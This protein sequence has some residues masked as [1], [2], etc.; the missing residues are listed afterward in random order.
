LRLALVLALALLAL[1]APARAA[2]L[3]VG[4][5][6][7][8]LVLGGDASAVAQWPALGVDVVRIHAQW[9][10]IAPAVRPAGFVAS[11]PASRGYDWSTLDRAVALIRA[12]G[13]RVALT[14]TGPGPLWTSSEPRKRNP[15]W[16]PSP[17]AF[18]AFAHAVAA[19]YGAVVDRYLVWNE[20][21]QG[22]WLQPQ[23]SCVRKV[24]TPVAPHEYRALVRAAAPAIHA[25]DPGSEVI[26]GELAPIGQKPTNANTALAPLPFLREMACV[27]SRYR[28]LH[29][30]RCR[31]FKPAAFDTFGYHPHPKQFAPD[32]A[33]P[34][35]DEAQFA[36]LP[37][38]FA[39]LDRLRSRLRFGGGVDL[40]EF[41]YQTSPP[42]H[43]IGVTLDE[44]ARYLQQAAYIAWRSP[45]VAEL[46][47][48]QWQ[49][50][51]VVTRGPGT[52]AYS[53]WQS[54]LELVNGTPKPA[55]AS[56][57]DPLVV[58]LGRGVIWGQVRPGALPL[59][60][61][62]I[63]PPGAADFSDVQDVPLGPDGSFAV[64]GVVRGAAYR[65][66][67]T[68]AAPGAAPR[69]SGIVDLAQAQTT[70]LRA[71]T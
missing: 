10:S 58:D 49:D 37:R 31:G 70:K 52:L 67:W 13:M 21:N 2:S 29:G 1:A 40:T 30:G 46:G 60:T 24:C 20:P 23:S 36:D 33:N 26:A 63:R 50:E 19:R 53:G 48:Y 57:P 9:G 17:A 64:G 3:E 56:F 15:R 45:R 35:Q 59:A 12:N 16:L 51:P 41:G 18:G 34:N 28:P 39:V 43:A 71:S 65:Y 54:G 68:P 62:Q 7:E 5:E 69:Y 11:D 44:Q 66:R 25:A 32:R 22:G 8:R 4:L 42:D 38:L 55:L 47:F 61:L 27:D 14:V 6:D